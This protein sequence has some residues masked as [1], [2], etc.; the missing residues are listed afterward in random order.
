MQHSPTKALADYVVQAQPGDLPAAVTKEAART[1]VN[2]LG[3]AVGGAHPSPIISC[4]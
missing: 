1:F 2:W 4:K 3:C